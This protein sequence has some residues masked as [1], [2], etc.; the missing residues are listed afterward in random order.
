MFKDDFVK[1]IAKM[2]YVGHFIV[3]KITKKLT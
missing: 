1:Q 2:H 3:L